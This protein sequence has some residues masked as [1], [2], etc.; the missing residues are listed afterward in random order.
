MH[1]LL[2]LARSP[3][4][5]RGDWQLFLIVHCAFVAIGMAPLLL[6]TH[7]LSGLEFTYPLFQLYTPRAL[8]SGNAFFN[9]LNL[10]GFP[11]FIGTDYYSMNPFTYLFTALL[12]PFDSL[13]AFVFANMVAGG[14]FC[15]LL[16]RR[17]GFSRAAAIIGGASYVTGSWLLIVTSQFVAFLPIPPLMISILLASRQHPLRACLAGTLLCTYLW[18]AVF[19]QITLMIFALSAAAAVILAWKLRSNGRI[20]RSPL[21]VFVV[22][23]V[24]ST[25]TVLPKLL[26]T[27]VYGDLS[28]RAAGVP[29]AEATSQGISALSPLRYL[30]PYAQFPFLNFGGDILMLYVGTFGFLF[31][32]TG[33][34]V[35]LPRA[36]VPRVR[37]WITGY[38]LLL[39]MA[40]NHSPLAAIVH[41]FPPFSYFRGAGRWM[42]LGTFVAA[43]IIAAGVDALVAGEA[44]K[45]RRMFAAVLGSAVF[46]LCA[47]LAAMQSVLTLL[48]RWPIALFQRYFAT[49]HETLGLQPPL[50]YYETFVERRIADLGAHPLFLEPRTL[51]PLLSL[52]VL[53]IVLQDRVWR[54]VRRTPWILVACTLLT[55][56]SVLF[57]Y[58]EYIPRDAI[59]VAIHTVEF[60]KAHPSL[61][62]GV[63][64]EQASIAAFR[65]KPSERDRIEWSLEYLV[66]NTNLYND[67]PILD[68]FDNLPSRRPT[69]LASWV[70]AHWAGEHWILGS[71]PYRIAAVPGSLH[72]KL[73]A[74]AKRKDMMDV[75]GLRYIVSA[76]PIADTRFRKV[77]E[78]IITSKRL[79]IAIYENPDARPKAYFADAIETVT[80]NEAETIHRMLSGTW[81]RRKSLIECEPECTPLK[82]SGMGDVTIVRDEGHALTIRTSSPTPQWLV[83]NVNRLPGWIVTIDSATARTVYANG[84]FFG[85]Q[86]PGGN[87]TIAWRFSL[88]QILRE[89]L[90]GAVDRT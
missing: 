2:R 90:H 57:W 21:I 79:P 65:E 53:A 35:Q 14:F 1:L 61:A 27:K 63:L 73:V 7:L 64:S 85:V 44:E 84:T 60:L 62:I 48:P 25:L 4:L 71:D 11:T 47:W 58:N 68:T 29:S 49:V 56:M 9:A 28:W 83:L 67:I 52:F 75:M 45:L 6:R 18:W 88:M 72:D 20:A 37:W 66:P 77:F 50:T 43:P 74:Y 40:I 33:I 17:L 38:V 89:G 19:L 36:S 32:L 80:E 51:F 55:S 23:V 81:P 10:N 5:R 42:L 13:N 8:L 41:S 59:P 39:L 16:I 26:I 78:A 34:F 24:I 46:V 69:A 76:F 30:F 82:P 87:H 15:S 86:V 70:G 12:P 3:L 54:S 22:S 31:L